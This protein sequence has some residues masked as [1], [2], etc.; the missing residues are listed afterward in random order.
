MSDIFAVS[1]SVD[2]VVVPKVAVELVPVAFRGCL[3]LVRLL[4]RQLDCDKERPK[5][6][7]GHELLVMHQQYFF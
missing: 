1:D 3:Q 2:L 7:E 4:K 6:R 5:H